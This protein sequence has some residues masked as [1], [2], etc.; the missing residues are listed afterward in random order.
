MNI[1]AHKDATGG[2]RCLRILLADDHAVL[3]EGLAMLIDV[4]PDMEVVA[5]ARN[6]REAVHLCTVHQPDVVVLDVSMPDLDGAEA[7]ERVRE[8][9][10]TPRILALTRHADQGYLR[11]LLRAGAAGYVLKRSAADALIHAIRT[12]ARGGTYIDPDMIGGLVSRAVGA[13]EAGPVG[14]VMRVDLTEREE[15]V[16]RLIAWGRSN[17]E[18]AGKLGLSVKTVESYK[19]TALQK[20]QLRSRTDILRYALSQQWLGDEAAPE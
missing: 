7:A 9:C 10:P 11:R 12:V 14:N 4:Q 20:L 3:R 8:L 6:G 5:Q 19:A 18:A 16:L 15:Q 17:K 2:Q 1:A 13:P